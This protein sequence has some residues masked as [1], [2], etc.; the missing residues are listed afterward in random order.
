[1][2]TTAMGMGTDQ[3]SEIVHLVNFVVFMGLAGFDDVN[4]KQMGCANR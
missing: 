2:T 3:R 4:T 1:M